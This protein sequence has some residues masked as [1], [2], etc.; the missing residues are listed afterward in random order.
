MNNPFLQFGGDAALVARQR[1]RPRRAMRRGAVQ[2]IQYR[3]PHPPHCFCELRRA[4]L[5]FFTLHRRL[6]KSES[7]ILA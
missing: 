4:V 2:L 6:A 7:I 1:G 5:Y 3:G